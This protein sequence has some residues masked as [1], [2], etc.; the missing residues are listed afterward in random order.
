M[1][2][3]HKLGP[4]IVRVFLASKFAYTTVKRTAGERES[5]VTSFKQMRGSLANRAVV[6]T[7]FLFILLVFRPVAL[8]ALRLGERSD[9]SQGK[10][11][12]KTLRADEDV[13]DLSKSG[14]DAPSESVE[15]GNGES[16]TLSEASTSASSAEDPSG[17]AEYPEEDLEMHIEIKH[18]GFMEAVSVTMKGRRISD[19]DVSR[20]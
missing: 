4:L 9:L 8:L 13:S 5:T 11:A 10:S 14:E 3:F 17:L 2:P 1:L 20:V 7:F 12:L 19:E 15:S 6:W 16:V 18:L